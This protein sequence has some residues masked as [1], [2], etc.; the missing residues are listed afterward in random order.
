MHSR[1]VVGMQVIEFLFHEDTMCGCSSCWVVQ[2]L[3]Y[4][5]ISI[6]W[7]TAAGTHSWKFCFAF[8]MP[9]V[10]LVQPFENV[11]VGLLEDFTAFWNGIY[12]GWKPVL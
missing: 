3:W 5:L 1:K 9:E 10:T 2:V 7:K 8:A 11:D 12:G 4:M 6:I